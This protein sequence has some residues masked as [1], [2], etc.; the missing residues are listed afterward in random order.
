MNNVNQN[1]KKLAFTGYG[2]NFGIP[3]I[4]WIVIAILGG[5]TDGMAPLIHMMVW[6]PALLILYILGVIFLILTLIDLF[7]TRYIEANIFCNIGV[8]IYFIPIFLI[9]LFKLTYI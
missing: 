2:I 6:L 7:K 9:I 1:Y 3:L 5:Y 4:N 8:L